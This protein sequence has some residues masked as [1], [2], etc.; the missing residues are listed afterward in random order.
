MLGSYLGV[1]LSLLTPLSFLKFLSYFSG[2]IL[3]GNHN[4]ITLK[5]RVLM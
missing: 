1:A 3:Y 5:V 4:S 2:P